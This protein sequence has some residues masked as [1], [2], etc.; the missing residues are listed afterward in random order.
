[1]WLNAMKVCDVPRNC[2]VTSISTAE[3]KAP[4]TATSA[5]NEIDDVDGRMAMITPMKPTSTALQRRQP[6]FSPRTIADS[7]TTMIGADR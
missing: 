3:T 4:A 6:T 5:P 2:R 7:A 1:M